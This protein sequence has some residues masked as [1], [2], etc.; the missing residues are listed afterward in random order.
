MSMPTEILE[1]I[2]SLAV[3]D[4]VWIEATYRIGSWEQSRPFDWFS[5]WVPGLL[6]VSKTLRRVARKCLAHRFDLICEAH[7]TLFFIY[8]KMSADVAKKTRVYFK[9]LFTRDEEQSIA[10]PNHVVGMAAA[11][12]T[13]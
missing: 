12:R 8:G 10:G 2:I 7:F 13:E 4:T 6:V 9:D 11:T 1:K 5:E 3:P